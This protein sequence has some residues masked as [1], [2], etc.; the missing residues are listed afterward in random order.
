MK[1]STKTDIIRLIIKEIAVKSD[2]QLNLR[3]S[4]DEKF[5]KVL[6]AVIQEEIN[7]LDNAIHEI[8]SLEEK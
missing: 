7:E 6:I 2:E 8:N 4:G 5:K 3:V 1:K